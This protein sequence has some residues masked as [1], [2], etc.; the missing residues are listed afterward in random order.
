MNPA[1]NPALLPRNKSGRVKLGTSRT[2]RLVT[3]PE[4][5]H[6]ASTAMQAPAATPSPAPSTGGPVFEGLDPFSLSLVRRLPKVRPPRPE[7]EIKP[8]DPPTQAQAQPSTA[9]PPGLNLASGGK[10]LAVFA[11]L[12]AVLV[13]ANRIMAARAAAAEAPEP[14]PLPPPT[15]Q[16]PQVTFL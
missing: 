15:K 14:R 7:K 8:P 3:A 11:G 16:D 9:K 4:A 6:G 13:I 10:V 5:A 2:S 12:V 1:M